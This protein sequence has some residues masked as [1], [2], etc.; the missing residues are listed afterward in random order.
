MS[1]VPKFSRQPHSFVIHRGKVGKFIKSLETD[2]RR[3]LEP[4][5]A[6]NLKVLKKNNIKDFIVNGAVLGVNNMLVL[7]LSDNAAQLRFIRFP[8][9]PTL[10]FRGRIL[11]CFCF[12]QKSSCP[13]QCYFYLQTL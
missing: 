9:G 7:T 11:F 1:K 3:V 8:Q 13:F 5:T 2:L 6:K 4:N 12:F 10:T